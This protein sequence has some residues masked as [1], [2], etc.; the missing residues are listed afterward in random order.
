L[1]IRK[2]NGETTF[3]Y[4]GGD[5]RDK[6]HWGK[7]YAGVRLS[8]NHDVGKCPNNTTPE[9][10]RGVLNNGYAVYD[11]FS[12]LPDFPKEIWAFYNGAIYYASSKNNQ[13]FHAFPVRNKIDDQ[14]K[15]KL[16]ADAIEDN[17]YQEFRAWL[18]GAYE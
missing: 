7:P 11:E 4:D 17:K 14:I 15:E 12:D 13:A 9:E 6:H 3:P 2:L 16:M 8:G 18:R 5:H 1:G 10:R